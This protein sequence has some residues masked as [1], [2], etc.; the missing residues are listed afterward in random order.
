MKQGIK[1]NLFFC[2]KIPLKNKFELPAATEPSSEEV[3]TERISKDAYRILRLVR[4]TINSMHTINHSTEESIIPKE[5]S[6]LKKKVSEQT[7]INT[8]R[9]DDESHQ[10]N[11]IKNSSLSTKRLST[12]ENESGFS[13]ICSYFI[14]SLNEIGLPL[15]SFNNSEVSFNNGSLTTSEQVNVLWV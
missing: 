2:R 12:S 13:S 15:N 9:N 3:E 1:Q 10:K 7:A 6:G 8:I 4:N 5:M 11:I 14:P